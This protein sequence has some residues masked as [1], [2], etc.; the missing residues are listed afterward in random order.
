[1]QKISDSTNTASAAGEFTEGNS[2]AGVGATQIK[3][4][5][6]NAIQRELIAVI[7]GAGMAV[8][9]GYDNQLLAAIKLLGVQPGVTPGR[10]IG[11]RVFSDPGTFIY[12]PTPETRSVVVE[13]QGGGGA[14]GSPA[15]TSSGQVSISS[16]GCSGSYAKSRMT[17]GFSGVS[18]VVGRGGTASASSAGSIGGVGG[19]S[20]FGSAITAPGGNG[21]S[22]AG[23]ANPPYPPCGITPGASGVGGNIYNG[24]SSAPGVAFAVAVNSI[25][26][27]VGGSSSF[28]GGGPVGVVGGAGGKAVGFGSG[29]GGSSCGPSSG[30]VQGGA[31]CSGAVIVYEYA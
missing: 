22:I 10:L 1:M 7:E 8:N 9:K 15:A 25:C 6:L 24:A 17:Y 28:G 2:A 26:G 3:A 16:G 18:V 13:V 31:G 14:G 12:I 21:G 4:P 11:V 29:G 23:P 27:S 30:S 20:S 19:S 5:W